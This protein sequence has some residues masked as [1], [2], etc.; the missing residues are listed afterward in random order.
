MSTYTEIE[1]SRKWCPMGRIGHRDG[2][3]LND[4]DNL[5]GYS[6]K[7]VG[8]RCMMWRQVSTNLATGYCGLAGKPDW[9]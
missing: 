1:A 6:T 2:V 9:F 3:T 5:P 7:C 8:S 4:P